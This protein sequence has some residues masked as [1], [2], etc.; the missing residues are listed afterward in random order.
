MAL[1]IL[2]LSVGAESVAD[3]ENWI[4]EKLALRR[5]A[6]QPLEHLHR[7]R[8]VP[9][10]QAELLDGGSIY[11]VIK[12]EIACREKIVALE[13]FRDSDGISRCRI[14]ME[15]KIIRIEPRPLRAFQGWRYLAAKDAPPDTAK[16]GQGSASLPEPLRKELREL[17]LL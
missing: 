6:K 11:W 14:V 7:T 12:G 15:P 10:R 9:K 2:K 13:P 5:K 16:N 4:A 1:H 8:M 17:G 3:L